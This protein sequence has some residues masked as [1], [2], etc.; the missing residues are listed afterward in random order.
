MSIE[1]SPRVGL[2]E[3]LKAATSLEQIKALSAEFS[4][5]KYASDKTRRRV[6]RIV[7]TKTKEL[8]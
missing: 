1:N 3:Q 5:F 2:L 6:G 8:S 4:T 7:L